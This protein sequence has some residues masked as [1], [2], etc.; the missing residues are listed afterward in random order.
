MENTKDSFGICEKC[1]IITDEGIHAQNGNFCNG[2]KNLINSERDF[3]ALIVG[4]GMRGRNSGKSERI[5]SVVG[6][7]A[8]CGLKV[9][10]MRYFERLF[11]DH[12]RT[13]NPSDY[14]K[15]SR[16]LSPYREVIGWTTI[17]PN[18]PLIPTELQE[19][20]GHRFIFPMVA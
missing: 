16:Y 9:V 2:T 13:L 3:I 1:G 7:F 5:K 15:I 19:L 4:D 14:S 6:N 18:A 8:Q 17:N 20:H 11:K 12:N 10:E